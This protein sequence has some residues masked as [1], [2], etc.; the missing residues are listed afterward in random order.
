MRMAE[1]AARR[2]RD[3]DDEDQEDDDGSGSAGV[4]KPVGKVRER[5][6]VE[7]GRDRVLRQPFTQPPDVL[8]RAG[9]LLARADEDARR[10]AAPAARARLVG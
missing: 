7:A 4:R 5:E 6:P 10:W 3:E 8:R 1:A 9:G 2:G